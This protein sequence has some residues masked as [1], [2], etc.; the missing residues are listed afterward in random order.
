MDEVWRYIPGHGHVWDD[1]RLQPTSL[2]TENSE[3]ESPVLQLSRYLDE[4]PQERLIHL[5]A[6]PDRVLQKWGRLFDIVHPSSRRSC[7]FTRGICPRNRCDNWPNEPLG[8]TQLVER[9]GSII[10]MNEG[11]DV[12]SVRYLYLNM[13]GLSV[14]KTTGTFDKFLEA[15]SKNDTEAI[16]ILHPLRLR[17]FS[18]TELLRL[19]HFD[20]SRT[21][22]APSN[23]DFVWPEGVSTK[24]KY[25][26]IGNSVNVRVVTE[27]INF[28][29]E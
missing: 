17:Y 20:L 28:L 3:P 23:V 13:M 25:R 5:H 9:A 26:L 8:Y 2:E 16:R 19:F 14:F 12:S 7:C 22:Y 21:S 18:P 10:Q 6:V 15:Q 11:L 1:P 29:F 24:T 4:S 27:L